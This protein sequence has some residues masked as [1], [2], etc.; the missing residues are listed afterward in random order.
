MDAHTY[1]DKSS[2]IP[3]AYKFIDNNI[4][5][6]FPK[7]YSGY[8]ITSVNGININSILTELDDTLIYGTPGKKEVEIEKAFMNR[9]SISSL[10][11]LRNTNEI[12]FEI[13]NKD[14]DKRIIDVNA[15]NE[16]I[17]P[18]K[19]YNEYN[20]KESKNFKY[21]IV[22]NTLILN[23]FSFQNKYKDLLIKMLNS[24]DNEDLS[25]ID[26]II[27]NVRGNRGGN[28]QLFSPY[29]YMNY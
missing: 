19:V 24:L 2:I 8:Y 29:I 7:E 12:R 26:K 14:G 18:I 4:F 17:E 11:S 21:K 23:L 20:F 10:R 6:A 25:S 9:Y 3:L 28:G 27:L 16:R 13:V 22:D 15:L 5:I 1:F